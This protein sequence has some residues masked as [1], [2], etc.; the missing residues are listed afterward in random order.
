MKQKLKLRKKRKSDPEKKQAKRKSKRLEK[1]LE[2]ELEK[3][4]ILYNKTLI[5]R[6]SSK[7]IFLGNLT[8]FP[9]VILKGTLQLDIFFSSF[10]IHCLKNLLKYCIG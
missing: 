6:E 1:A 10:Q 5:P 9:Y 7:N 2:R 4:K 3:E 8:S